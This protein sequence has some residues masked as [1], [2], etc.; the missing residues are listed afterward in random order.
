VQ[1][2]H[3]L[4]AIHASTLKTW[5]PGTRPG[6]TKNLRVKCGPQKPPE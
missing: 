5:M 1:V 4:R 6:M 2:V 3:V